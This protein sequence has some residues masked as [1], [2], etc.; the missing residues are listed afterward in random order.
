MV[1]I[2]CT[3]HGRMSPRYR[4]QSRTEGVRS[5]PLFVGL[6]RNS[7]SGDFPRGEKP[8]GGFGV[9]PAGKPHRALTLSPVTL[10]PRANRTSSQRERR[11]HDT[12]PQAPP[13]GTL[14]TRPPQ[15]TTHQRKAAGAAARLRLRLRF[16]GPEI[17][18]PSNKGRRRALGWPLGADS[19]PRSRNPAAQP[20]HWPTATRH[21][22]R[23]QS[24]LTSHT[25]Q[26]RG[27]VCRRGRTR[28]E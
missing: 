2:G 21:S 11:T 8:R 10:R 28:P 27:S 19:R 24:P 13:P 15:A 9:L 22:R 23:M 4:A 6:S 7:G 12:R 17:V 20:R 16:P 5:R 14:L 26:A 25:Q 1:Y 3:Q 18:S